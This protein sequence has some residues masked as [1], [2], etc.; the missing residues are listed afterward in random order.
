MFTL[1]RWTNI[2]ILHVIMNHTFSIDL[3]KLLTTSFVTIST[4][5]KPESYVTTKRP[6]LW[7]ASTSNKISSFGGEPY[8]VGAELSVWALPPNVVR[9]GSKIFHLKALHS[10]CPPTT[11]KIYSRLH[12]EGTR[13]AKKNLDF[14]PAPA[15][16][17]SFSFFCNSRERARVHNLPF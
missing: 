8:E 12:K 14:F 1:Q 10:A 5:E 7:L 4:T 17:K 16:G 2:Y 9:R 6:S 3:L 13:F 15:S 11:R